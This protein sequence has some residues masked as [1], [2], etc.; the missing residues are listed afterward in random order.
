MEE[1]AKPAKKVKLGFG[2]VLGLIA[3]GLVVAVAA[4]VVINAHNKTSNKK[5]RGFSKDFSI[6]WA[7]N[8]TRISDDGN[9]LELTLDQESGKPRSIL[10][11][12]CEWP[13]LDYNCKKVVNEVL[14]ITAVVFFFVFFFLFLQ[15]QGSSQRTCF[16][17][18]ASRWTSSWYQTTQLELSLHT[19][20]A[21]LPNLHKFPTNLVSVLS[22]FLLIEAYQMNTT[23]IRQ[24]CNLLFFNLL[25]GNQDFVL[26]MFS[27]EGGTLG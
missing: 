2:V 26:E 8:H 22:I 13:H 1:P 9:R 19:M 15:A 20:W 24:K 25:Q 14:R 23:L 11:F 5:S 3:L 27:F 16:C 12:S 21:F 18:E 4:A 6:V 7:E 10:I 17:L